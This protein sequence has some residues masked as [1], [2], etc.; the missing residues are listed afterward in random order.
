MAADRTESTGSMADLPKNLLEEAKHLEE[1]L[2][3]PASKLKEIT[4]HFVSELEKGKS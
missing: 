4:D 3:V 2:A 1:M